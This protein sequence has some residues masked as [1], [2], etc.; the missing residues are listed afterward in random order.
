[1]YEKNEGV[2]SDSIRGR[3]ALLER[4]EWPHGRVSYGYDSLY[5]D[6]SGNEKRVKRNESFRKGHGWRRLLDKN[7]EEAKVVEWLF[8]EFLAKDVSLRQL[9]KDLSS[10]NIPRPDGKS[11]AWTDDAVKQILQNKAYAG[12][13]YIEW[14]GKDGEG[15]YQEAARAIP[16]IVTLDTWRRA[17]EKLGINR[18]EGRKVQPRKASPLS[19]IL[20]C[21]H[22]GYPLGQQPKKDSSGKRYIN[23]TCS[24]ATK[25]PDFRCHQWGVYEEEILPNVI[26]RLVEE[27][28][29]AILEQSNA[30]RPVEGEPSELA[31]LNVKLATLNEKLKREYEQLLSA[32]VHRKAA[33][34]EILTRWEA[35]KAQIERQIQ[36]LTITEGDVTSFAKWWDTVSGHLVIVLEIEWQPARRRV[37]CLLNGRDLRRLKRALGGKP[38]TCTL[39]I[40]MFDPD[41]NDMGREALRLELDHEGQVWEHQEV[42]EPVKPAVMIEASRF[43]NL[44]RTLG[45]KVTVWWKPRMVTKRGK[46]QESSRYLPD[47]AEIEV[48]SRKTVVAVKSSPRRNRSKQEG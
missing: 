14:A 12:Y 28:D 24:S 18:E 13:A 33:Y 45:F 30:K 26:E 42:D 38:G 16:D 4:G 39:E 2:V 25:R 7:Q 15:G 29:R 40:A 41:G 23:F 17:V 21:G 10:R 37:P 22:C 1:M 9:A 46:V 20:F 5:I 32:P 43:R 44:L 48:G 19:G 31:S 8:R 35:E 11:A 47:Y 3:I 36:N 34:E 6:P 27:V